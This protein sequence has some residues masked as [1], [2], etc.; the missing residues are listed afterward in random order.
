MKKTLPM[1]V[2]LLAAAFPALADDQVAVD[3]CLSSW[4]KKAPFKKGTKPDGIIATG[5][6]VF[7]VGSGQSGN[8][9]PTTRPALYLVRPAVNVMGKSTI[10]LS[11]PNGW[12]CFRSNVTV[13]GAMHIDAHCTAHI[14]S[15]KEDGTS[16][17]AVD[18]SSKGVA[19][20]GALRVTR[21]G[22]PEGK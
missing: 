6:K 8:D 18:E 3:A 22:C 1:L 5:V 20:F 9:E 13:A 14:A 2:V 15:A 21:F 11:N 19:V 16:V 7:G 10:K 4:G 17:G 12:Y